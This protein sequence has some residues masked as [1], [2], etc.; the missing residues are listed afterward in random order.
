MERPAATEYHVLR[1]TIAARGSLRPVLALAGLAVWAVILTAVL[2]LI[3]YPMAAVIPLLVLLVTFEVIRPL[4]F[5]AERLGRYLQVFYEEAGQPER[6]LSE[7]PAWE[8]VAM[9]LSAV[10]GT[11]GHP[12]FVPVFFLATVGNTLPV[13]LAQPPAT[14]IELAALGVP[15]L[16]FMV[17]LFHADRAM[18]RQRT[19]ELEQFRALHKSG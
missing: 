5:G 4:H 1:D 3:P 6:P 12:L 9:R 11:G 7:T 10:P 14:P 15:H 19:A 8:R 18:R 2:A 16:A 17:W 13:L